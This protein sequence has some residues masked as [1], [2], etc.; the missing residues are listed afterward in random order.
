MHAPG[1]A[2]GAV[3][4]ALAMALSFPAA[5]DAQQPRPVFR[6]GT[7]VVRVDVTVTNRQGVPADG[8]S[9][10]DFEVLED[11]APQAIDSFQLVHA[12]GQ[13]TDDRAL[14]IR[15]P[16]HAAAEAARDDVRLFLIFWDEYHIG[17]FIPAQRGREALTEFVRTAFGPT[18]LVGVMDQLTTVDSIRFTRDRFALADQ[19]HG[20]KGRLGV[21]IPARS[22]IEEGHLRFPGDI[23]RLRNE[24]SMSALMAAAALLGNFREGR[25]SL[26]FVSQGLPLP[27]GG[28]DNRYTDIVRAANTNNTAIYTFDPA[29]EV[30]RRPLSLVALAQDTGGRPFVGSNRPAG[31]LAQ[32]VR[33]A[34]AYYLLG[35]ASPAP[36]DGKFHRIKVRV[37]KDGY[38]VRARSGYFTSTPGEMERERVKAVAAVVPTDVERALDELSAVSRADRVVDLRVGTARG[39]GGRTRVTLAWAPH[40]G[41]GTGGDI[42]VTMSATVPGG[43]S[44]FA[45]SATSA[46]EVSFDAPPGDIVIATTARNGRGEEIDG[47]VRRVTVP[48]FD[49]STLAIGSPVVLRARTARDARNLAALHAEVGRAFDRTDRLFIRFPVYG[50]PDAAASAHLL[51]GK[52]TEL[53]ALVLQDVGDGVYQIDLPLSVSARGDYLVAVEATRGAESVRALVPVRVR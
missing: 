14:E 24:V 35:Y 43:A 16:E 37:R 6:A 36:F 29:S 27:M 20:L 42:T 10:E 22:A 23:A 11:G 51:N 1:L 47:D 38:D 12:D 8:L 49:D 31:L 41:A 45:A 15:G 19:V 4:I 44:V 33:D 32:M 50:G 3:A 52:G 7:N 26:L 13:P 46:R 21:F 17:Q 39:A 5:Q 25:K 9:R 18:D 53:R 2:A 48:A 40:P 34:S 30:G 28:G